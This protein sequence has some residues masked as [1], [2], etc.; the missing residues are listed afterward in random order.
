MIKKYSVLNRPISP[1]LTIYIPLNSSVFSIWHRFT[2]VLL[3]FMLIFFLS[4]FKFTVIC[5]PLWNIYLLFNN[6]NIFMLKAWTLN[7]FWV[8]IIIIF[9]YHF[10]NGL[11]HLYW[12]IGFFLTKKSIIYSAVL[13]SIIILI[14]MFSQIINLI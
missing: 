5:Y 9:F 12:D 13:I 8:F 7:F 3:S 1:H 10:L 4:I 6:F 2:A 11:R 14:I